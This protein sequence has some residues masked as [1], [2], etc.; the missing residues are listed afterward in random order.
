LYN[1]LHKA[2]VCFYSSLNPFIFVYITDIM[3]ALLLLFSCIGISFIGISQNNYQSVHQEQ[4]EYFK[5]QGLSAEDY[6][7]LNVPAEMSSRAKNGNCDLNKIVF[8]WHPYWS[9]GLQVNYDWSLL[10]DMSYFSYEVNPNTGNANT[11]HNFMTA[12]AVTDALNNGVRVNLCVTLFNDHAT[13]FGNPTARQTLI[14]NLIT[15]VQNRGAHG[16]NIDFESMASSTSA[17]YNAYIIDLSQQM[18]AA[19]PGCQISLALHAVDWSGFYNIAAL[20]PHVDY[21]CIMGYDY[22][23]SGSANAGPNDPLYHFTPVASYNRTLSRSTTYYHQQGAPKEKIILGLPYYGREW[24]VSSQTLPATTTG[25]GNAVFYRNVKNN[26]SGF[27]SQAN[28][29]YEPNSRSVYYN[30]TNSGVLRQHFIS[31]E[32]EL[33]ERMDFAN[34]RGLA[35]IGIWALGYDDGY[36]ELWDEIENHMTTCASS[37]CNG[38]IWDMGGGP[39]TPYY[40]DENYTFTI[41]PLGAS[42]LSF[43]FTQFATQ[44]GADLLYIYDGP[45]IASPQIPGSPFSGANSPGSFSSAGGAV[46]FRFTSNNSTV[47]N[48]F[49]ASYTC[50]TDNIPPITS[51]DIQGVWQTDD[52]TADFQDE[53]DTNGTGI[54]RRFYHVGH[55]N[56]TEWRANQLRGFFADHF[57]LNTLHSDWISYDGTWSQNGTLVQT[58]EVSGNTN[59]SAPLNQ[60]LSN[61]HLYHYKSKISGSGGNRRA[62]LHFFCDDDQATNRGNS[63]FVWLRVEDNALQFYRVT[64]NSFGTPVINVPFNINADQWYDVKVSYDRITGNVRIYVDDQFIASWTDPSPLLTGDYVSFRSG[65]AIFEVDDFVVYRTRFPSVTVTV[66]DDVNK[67]IQFQNPNP[68]TPSGRVLSVVRDFANNLSDV[69][70]EFVNVDWTPPVFDW[71]ND[72][73][74]ADLDTIYTFATGQVDGNWSAQDPNSDIS[75]YDYAIGTLPYSDNIHAWT[76]NGTGTNVTAISGNLAVD[77]WYYFS[78]RATNGAGLVDSL[79]SNGFRILFDTS[80]LD[81]WNSGQLPRVYPNPAS[82]LVSI[83]GLIGSTRIELFDAMGRKISEWNNY[84]AVFQTNIEQLSSGSYFFRIH[85]TDR[86]MDVKWMKR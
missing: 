20:N 53:D 41:A 42:E 86:I 16:V 47:G 83:E 12:Q 65:N 77:V 55:F 1:S 13:F 64:N 33:A 30:F 5:A 74:F 70:Q 11:T 6:E 76:S 44:A 18:K 78:V 61:I 72:G 27:Y 22:Y 2:S 71:V 52:F 15:L 50:V 82:E 73:P 63:Y 59:L 66:G 69:A 17:D 49:Y 31:E 81:E 29:N 32:E 25:T 14:N 4:F 8:G 60:S 35:G 24:P 34:K 75:L 3:R 62:G 85:S 46:T 79:A 51:I 68:S 80:S 43:N 10:S 9:N 54:D 67:D 38:E 48:G 36:S 39:N 56:G 19:I 23:W 37:P 21:F 26:V 84:D 7:Q 58:D 28:R 40:N 57:D 45:T